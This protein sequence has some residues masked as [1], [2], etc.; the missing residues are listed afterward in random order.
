MRY[1]DKCALFTAYFMCDIIEKSRNNM[2]HLSR[3][4][5]MH[6]W[7]MTFGKRFCLRPISQNHCAH[8]FSKIIHE[9]A[10]I[11]LHLRW[12]SRV[13]SSDWII[14]LMAR[15]NKRF[16]KANCPNFYVKSFYLQHAY[17]KLKTRKMRPT[18]NSVELNYYAKVC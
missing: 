7:C 15:G 13:F 4:C 8:Y 18:P 2:Y 16:Y 14:A 9:L 6:E 1:H 5:Y 12:V 11:A 3:S 17:W 10:L